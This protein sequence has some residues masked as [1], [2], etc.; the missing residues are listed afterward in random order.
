MRD[1]ID[2]LR[3]QLRDETAKAATFRAEAEEARTALADHTRRTD[4]KVRSVTRLRAALTNMEVFI[5]FFPSLL[6]HSP[7][8]SLPSPP[9]TPYQFLL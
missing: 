6:L 4:E 9:H 3:A 1:E 8:L 2:A 5:T 7:S